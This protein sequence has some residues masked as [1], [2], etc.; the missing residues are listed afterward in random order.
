VPKTESL[1][2]TLQAFLSELEGTV[3]FLRNLARALSECTRL[4]R[5]EA[6][7]HRVIATRSRTSQII[8]ADNSIDKSQHVAL[9]QRFRQADGPFC[10]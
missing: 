10:P 8:Y 2:V 9:E 3:A 1:T 5:G 6:Y 7:H 4:S